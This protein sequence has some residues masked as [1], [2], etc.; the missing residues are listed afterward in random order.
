LILYHEPASVLMLQDILAQAGYDNYK[1]IAACGEAISA[2]HDFGPDLILLELPVPDLGRFEVLRQLQLRI[3][4][5]SYLPIAIVTADLPRA[6]KRQVLSAGANDFIA[7]PFDDTDV[8]LRIRGLLETRF[9]HRA[10]DLRNRVLDQ[11]VSDRAHSME[12]AQVEILHRLALA[13]EY[14]DDITGYHTQRVGE[15]AALLG[16]AAKL[17]EQTVELIRMAAPLHDVGKIGIP[18]RLILKRQGL[19]EEEFELIKAHTTIGARLLAGSPFPI[20]QLAEKIALYH[21]ER[22]D[23]QGYWGSQGE[24]IPIEV[25]IVSIVDTFDVLTHERPYKKAWP[26]QDAIAEIKSQS[27]RQFDP[28]LVRVF[29]ALVRSNGLQVLSDTEGRPLKSPPSRIEGGRTP[30]HTANGKTGTEPGWPAE[31]PL[32]PAIGRSD[33][34]DSPG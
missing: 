29:T 13:A 11:D 21:H 19:T 12:E 15:L 10:L 18:D 20:L 2:F 33:S 32:A 23:G 4:P 27:G 24:A 26:V 14:R 28:H 17:P 22:W 25:R 31:N 8:V 3:P 7:K 5:Q 6:V 30:L 9:L 1:A 34:L 16:R